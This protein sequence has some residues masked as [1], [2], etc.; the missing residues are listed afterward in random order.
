MR[1]VLLINWDNYPHFATGGVYTW[2]KSLVD[3]AKDWE[4][5]VFNQLSNPNA[6]A[7]YQVAQNVKKVIGLPVFGTHRCEEYYP[8]NGPLLAKIGRTTDKVIERRFLPL[9]Q[10]FLSGVLADEADP[11]ALAQVVYELHQF[12][13]E[14]DAKKCFENG[15]TWETFLDHIKGD[16]LYKEMKLREALLNFQVIQR[17]LQVLSVRLPKVDII[18]SSLAWLP[19]LAGVSAKIESRCPFVIT[20]HGV[21]F[22]ELL[23]YYNM[24][25]YNEVSKLFWTV[26]TRNIIRTIY[27]S[28]DMII[29]VC[30]ANKVWEA[31]L[32][33]D[34]SKIRV[35]YNGVDTERFKPMRVQREDE[36]PTVVSVARV[37]VFKDIIGLIQATSYVR[38]EIPNVRTLVFGDATEQEY[39]ARCTSM[40]QRLHLEDNFKLM[41]GTKQPEKAYAR[42]D[43]VA[44]SSITEAFPFAVIEAMACG[45]AV[46]ATDV[47]GV[48]EALEGCGLLVRS[49]SPHD[50]AN[51]IIRLIE[52]RELRA[53]LEVAAIAR[54]REKFRLEDSVRQYLSVYAQLTT[55]SERSEPRREAE[56]LVSQ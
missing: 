26:F 23:L 30:N 34:E 39:S 2:V 25:L 29:P 21:A 51:A 55:Q 1:R 45:K 5:V 3:N 6:N 10:R 22:R 43:V 14:Y 33:A 18:H 20:E 37:S 31:K 48:R 41:G 42:A 4:F 9:Y 27:D 54:A 53:R 11:K 13:V 15:M 40:I 19:A 32:G 8:E 56:I 24:F 49:R 52:D 46:V 44:F 35:I 7:K 17:S 12:M 16:D 28:S 36:R 38:E 47:G 50:L